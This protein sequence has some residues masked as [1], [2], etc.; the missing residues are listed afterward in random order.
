M[1]NT[2]MTPTAS[3][4]VS[5]PSKAS[6]AQRSQT[7]DAAIAR[8]HSVA[9]A[10][11]PLL[12]GIAKAD[13]KAKKPRIDAA[14]VANLEGVIT[15]AETAQGERQTARVEQMEATVA[16]HAVAEKLAALLI[17]VRDLVATHNPDDLA[18]QQ[19]YGRGE[20]I[21]AK[22][23]AGTLEIAQ[24]FIAAYAGKWKEAA[25]DAGVGADTMGEITT[26]A[27]T[28]AKATVSR[29]STKTTGAR[30]TLS[31]GAAVKALRTMCAFAVRVV[32]SVYGKGSDELATLADPRPLRGR[33][34]AR[35]KAA[36]AKAKVAQARTSA[37]KAASRAK[38][39]AR[40]RTR[41]RMAK[42]AAM[43][44]LAA[45]LAQGAGRA[46]AASKGAKASSKAAKGT[47]KGAKATSKA[48]KGTSKAAKASSK[49]AKAGARA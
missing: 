3:V 11:A 31:R 27:G 37:R 6:R 14:W 38:A 17:Q 30:K 42:G 2:A 16:E 45:K 46:K 8:A 4:P 32:A 15:A 10:L 20:K 39:G 12:A 40:G 43:K 5:G 22:R 1:S 25:V 35:T 23:I 26:L 48:A 29:L 13:A 19:A 28:L 21:D 34:A 36:K 9:T 47:S 24:E 7:L 49:A 18:A 44:A 41:A 33:G